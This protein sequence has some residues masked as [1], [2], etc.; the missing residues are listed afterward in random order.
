MI[1]T[2]E[3]RDLRACLTLTGNNGPLPETGGS[4]H[5]FRQSGSRENAAVSSSGALDETACNHVTTYV[6]IDDA[7]TLSLSLT[8][9]DRSAYFVQWRLE[10]QPVSNQYRELDVRSKT[11]K[12]MLNRSVDFA[13]DEIVC[14]DYWGRLRR[15]RMAGLSIENTGMKFVSGAEDA[16]AYVSDAERAAG[17][18]RADV[19]VYGMGDEE[20]KPKLRKKT[21]DEFHNVVSAAAVTSGMASSKVLLVDEGE[22]QERED[23]ADAEDVEGASHWMTME[24]RLCSAGESSSIPSFGRGLADGLG[25]VVGQEPSRQEHGGPRGVAQR[26]TSQDPS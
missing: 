17:S 16:K 15:N 23:E 8:L 2:D 4:A 22:G 7:Q 13:L 9:S 1:V 25:R 19:Y 24:F 6:P 18:V 3:D 11:S 20:E 21:V 26:R 5:L 14:E 12:R 10:G